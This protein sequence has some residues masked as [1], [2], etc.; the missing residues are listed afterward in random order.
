MNKT[1]LATAVA[2]LMTHI[3][4]SFAQE[5][6]DT[7]PKSQA[8]ETMVVT[9]N[10]FEQSADSVL[11]SMSVATRYDIERI[12]AKSVADVLK[13]M[14]GVE[15]THN[16]GRG[17]NMSVMIRGTNSSHTLVM[18]DGVRVSSSV[19][20]GT[21]INQF[22]IGMVERIEVIRG[23]SAAK[24][25]SDAIGGVINIITRSTPGDDR[26]Q[27][28]V[29]LGSLGHKEANFVTKSDVND[30]GHLQIAAGFDQIDGYNVRP[31]STNAGDKHGSSAQ[32]ILLSYEHKISEETSGYVSAS[33]FDNTAE[34]ESYGKNHG[35]SERS[36][37][38]AQ[39]DH[40]S[41][42]WQSFVNANY[43]VVNAKNY[44]QSEGRDKASTHSTT[45][46]LNLQW[47]NLYQLNSSMELGGGID[48]RRESL[49][50]DA[51]SYGRKHKLA[52]ESRTNIG[53]FVSASY[54]YEALVLEANARHDRHDKYDNYNTWALAVGY[55]INEQHRIRANYGTAYKAPTYSGLLTNSDLEP[56]ESKNIE[57]GI[58]GAY[59]AFQWN[60]SAYDNKVDNLNFWYSIPN[61]PPY[62]GKTY[63]VDARIKGIEVD[64]QFATGMVQHTLVAEY[65]DH[66]DD[67]GTQLSR[68]AKENYKWLADMYFD[69]VSINLSYIFTGKRLDLP[70]ENPTSEDYLDAIGV[71]DMSASYHLSTDLVL[72]GK[73]SN[74]LNEQYE[75][76][77]SYPAPE[78]AYYV[79]ATYQF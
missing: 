61:L 19:G 58:S 5:A 21:G 47:A 24:Y 37:I 17:Q 12:Q 71:W 66:K 18:V 69:D 1:I 64:I 70:T 42:D 62:N 53:G 57:V 56:E 31:L 59:S 9:A 30:N 2:S 63:N 33:W 23:P 72:S 68:R 32:N 38:T 7:T 3:P 52:G 48:W 44:K 13:R 54:K 22:P 25:G 10:R 78:R 29:G 60:L 27:V 40:Q 41:G 43:Q 35:E 15:V 79:S 8:Q 36:A 14:P 20:S 6:A 28:T 50:D 16:G 26:K 55:Q 74:V 11:A 76:A 75:T 73:V 65:K 4:T 49:D 45:D 46:M 34:Y 67:K 77:K 39:V 51:F